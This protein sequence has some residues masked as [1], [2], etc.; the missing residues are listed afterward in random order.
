MKKGKL[1]LYL[2]T[3]LLFFIP[4]KAYASSAALSFNGD[5]KVYS[6]STITLTLYLSNIDATGGITSISGNLSF[7][8]SYLEYISSNKE[9]AGYQGEINTSNNYKMSLMSGNGVTK[10]TNIYKITFKAKKTG[11]TTVTFKNAQLSDN[12]GK[13]SANVSSKK[14]NITE[15]PSGNN[16]LNSLSINPGQINFNQNTTQYSVSVDSDITSVSISAAPSDA[17]ATVSGTGNKNL[18]YGNNTFNIVVKAPNGATKTY[19]IN[20]NRAD[21]RSNNANLKSLKV[22]NGNVQLNF[23]KSIT[24]Y[25]ISVPF[26]VGSLKIDAEAEDAKADVKISN[27]NLISEETVPVKVIVKAENGNTKTYIINTKRGKDPNKVLSTNNYLSSLSVS[28]GILSPSFNK[29]QE[30][31]IVYLPFEATSIEISATVEDSKYAIVDVE[32]NPKLSVGNNVFKY[33]VTAE[34]NSV[35]VYTITVVRGISLLENNLSSNVFLKSIDIKNGEL[36]T[37]FDKKINYYTYTGKIENAYPEDENSKIKIVEKDDIVNI[38]VESEAGDI[39]VYTFIK[40]KN[41]QKIVFIICAIVIVIIAFILGY[42]IGRK[43]DI[44]FKDA[45]KKIIKSKKNK[46]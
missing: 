35:R 40:A 17:S 41:T 36:L 14:I 39:G 20:V 43:R 46:K 9:Y 16:L 10:N 4:T 15:P 44:K 13:F 6:G 25:N 2:L 37:Y 27:N 23:N 26:E 1:I 45:V 19:T 3:F 21:N 5:S 34:D 29:E 33:S 8:S 7:D 11:S 12:V 24:E 22:N 18:N 31:Y 28:Q 32:G 42:L 30:N 38:I